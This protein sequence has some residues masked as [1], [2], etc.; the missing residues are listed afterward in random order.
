MNFLPEEIDDLLL[1]LEKKEHK[2]RPLKFM[3]LPEPT[4][5]SPILKWDDLRDIPLILNVVLGQTM[6]S[7]KEILDLKEGSVIK[8]DKL[9]GEPAEVIVEETVIGKGEV[10]VINDLFG[11][12]FSTE[13]EDR[14]EEAIE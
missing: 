3:P 11:I 12:R 10:L 14:S 9:V 4:T 5:S 13:S 1:K 2:I 7:L 8:L 6:L